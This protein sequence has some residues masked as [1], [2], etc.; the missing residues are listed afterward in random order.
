[1][2]TNAYMKKQNKKGVMHINEIKDGMPESGFAI[3]ATRAMMV[4]GGVNAPVNNC[5]GGS[6]P[7]NNCSTGNCGNCIAGCGVKE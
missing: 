4:L 1:M 2:D 3:I 6:C 7:T 5:I